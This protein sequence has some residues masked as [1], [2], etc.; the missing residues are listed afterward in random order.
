MS[1]NKNDYSFQ[2]EG[3]TCASCVRRVENAIKKIE[4]VGSV[5]VNL[6]TENIVFSIEKEKTTVDEISKAVSDAGYNLIIPSTASQ[7]EEPEKQTDRKIKYLANLRLEFYISLMLTIPVMALSML[8]M[9]EEFREAIPAD[10]INYVIFLFTTIVIIYPGRRFFISAAKL[11]RKLTSDMN[12]L[13][14]VGTGTAYI[15]SSIALFF[16]DLFGVHHLTDH[17]YFDTSATIITLILLG[18]FLEYRSKIRTNDAIKKLIGLQ[19]KTAKVKRGNTESEIDINSVIKGDIV[20]L[21]P[22]ERAPVDG[23]ILSGN[24]I[25]D[26]SMITGE[27][28]PAEKAAGDKVIGG[29]INLNGALELKATAVGKDTFLA[30]IIRFVEESQGSKAPIQ[31]LADKIAQYFVPIVILIAILTFLLW[32][33]IFEIGFTSSMINFISVLI[34]ACPCSLGLATPTAII[35]GTG[36]GASNGILIR[37]AESLEKIK[38]LDTIIFD[39]TG[40][41]TTGKLKIREIVPLNNFTPE[42]ILRL[43]VII[44]SRSTHPISNAFRDGNAQTGPEN[45]NLEDFEE[46]SGLGV[47]ATVNGRRIVIGDHRLLQENGVSIKSYTEK[48]TEQ[49]TGLEIFISIDGIVA[50]VFYIAD[51]LRPGAGNSIKKLIDSGI[52]PVMLTGDS[53]ENARLISEKTGIRRYFARVLPNEKA[54]KVKEI[55]SLGKRVG[56]VGDGINDSPALAVAEVGI[57]MGT[58][59]DIAIETADLTLVK[60]ELNDLHKAI[61]LSRNT[62]N[63]IRQNLFWAFVYNIIGIPLAVSG[64][65]NPMI[66]AA[67]MAFSSVSVIT[68]SLRLKTKSLS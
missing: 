53:E 44:E 37:N 26:E 41:L 54:E 47:K 59:T 55:Q 19:P 65:L 7:S 56:M 39:K 27:S 49:K 17:L 5:N 28:I 16:P 31:S 33:F 40:T 46:I 15:Y 23:V 29:T 6:A 2:I 30:H 48:T 3:M 8:M 64:L 12:T 20:I 58:G 36:V 67:A 38:N 18:K 52:E 9:Y 14:A 25:M 45:F 1:E 24:S 61:K 60:G 42:E 22:G 21:R 11:F 43:A 34:I 32:Y 4:G 57:A 63:T 66:A 35:V 13:V 68:N 62:I 50:G 10:L 51:E